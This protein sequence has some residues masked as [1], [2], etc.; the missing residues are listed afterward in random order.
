[1]SFHFSIVFDFCVLGFEIVGRDRENDAG[2]FLPRECFKF[3]A[4]S[5]VLKIYARWITHS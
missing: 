5:F 1:M 4:Q 2:S 3:Q